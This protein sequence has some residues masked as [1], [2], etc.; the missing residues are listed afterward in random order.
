MLLEQ[1]SFV[2]KMSYGNI[3]A[4]CKAL[5]DVGNPSKVAFV[6]KSTTQTEIL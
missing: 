6:S 2:V 4:M 1:N 3:G 5:N